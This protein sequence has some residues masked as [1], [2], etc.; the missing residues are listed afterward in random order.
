MYCLRDGYRMQAKRLFTG[1][2]EYTC[3]HCKKVETW[4]C[5]GTVPPQ[6]TKPLTPN[7]ETR[8]VSR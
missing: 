1:D 5:G 2:T 6:N 8:N 3:P 4:N 7:K